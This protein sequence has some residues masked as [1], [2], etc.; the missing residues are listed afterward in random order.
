M[1]TVTDK[2][3]FSPS[4]IPDYAPISRTRIFEAI[5]AGTLPSH[6]VGRRTVILRDDLVDFIRTDG[7]TAA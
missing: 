3:A 4:E 5:R 6:K 1:P 2:I 7:G